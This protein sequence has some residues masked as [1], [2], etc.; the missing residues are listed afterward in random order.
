MQDLLKR[1]GFMES[2]FKP[3][4][5]SSVLSD[6]YDGNWYKEFKGIDGS[7]FFSNPRNIGLILNFDFFNPFKKSKYSLGVIYA[8]IINLPREERFLWKNVLTLAIIPGPSEPNLTIN[9]YLRPL[10]DE[11]LECWYTG[12]RLVEPDGLPALYKFALGVNTC[13]LPALRKIGGFLSQ[14]ARQGKNIIFNPKHE[15]KLLKL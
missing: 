1:K 12:I 9:S 15:L 14:N 8:V 3:A 11:L 2:L 7:L 13:D 10:V 5:K 4:K 6:I